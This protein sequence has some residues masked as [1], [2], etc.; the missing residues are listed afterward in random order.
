MGVCK[1]LA[2]AV[3]SLPAVSVTLELDLA[4]LQQPKFS[5]SDPTQRTLISGTLFN[6][7]LEQQRH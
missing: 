4:L 1:A 7:M 6:L 5:R 2:A 3:R